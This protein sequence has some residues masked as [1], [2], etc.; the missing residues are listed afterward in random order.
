ME[1]LT[2]KQKRWID[3]YIETGS[4]A[5][6][7][8]LAGYKANSDKAYRNIGSENLAKLGEHLRAKLN[9]KE[10]AR[11]AKADEVLQFLTSVLRGDVTEEVIVTEGMMGGG[12]SARY[13]DKHVGAR[14]RLKAAEMLAKRYGL[15]TERVDMTVN[16]TGV[17]YIPDADPEVD[18]D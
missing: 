12:S 6:A 13:M 14:D 16:D 15:L 4:A 18:N 10:D 1:K 7:A 9:A 17:V 3:H 8:R 2:E 5:E 11:I